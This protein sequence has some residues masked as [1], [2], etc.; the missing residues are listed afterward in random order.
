V[1]RKPI[2]LA[3]AVAALSGCSAATQY[4]SGAIVLELSEDGAFSSDVETTPEFLS[5]YDAMEAQEYVRAEGLLDQALARKPRD[6]YALLAMGTVHE[7]SGRYSSA[8]EFYRSAERYG[9]EATGA[10]L[11]SNGRPGAPV[12]VS[13][14][15]RE[16]LTRL[17]N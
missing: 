13:D 4:D 1:P 2:A 3:I 15:A 9:S 16:N 5:A 12:S 10:R 17:L 8:A 7:R 14:A 6:P 11:S